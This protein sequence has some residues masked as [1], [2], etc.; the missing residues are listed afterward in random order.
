MLR[1]QQVAVSAHGSFQQ[2]LTIT[3]AED[4]SGHDHR[5]SEN[6]KDGEGPFLIS[7]SMTTAPLCPS[8]KRA[9][10]RAL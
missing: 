1:W 8:H 2:S 5:R 10:K 6:C 7:G 4:F 9:M 3:N